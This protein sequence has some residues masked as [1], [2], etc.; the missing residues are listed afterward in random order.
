M[1]FVDEFQEEIWQAKYQY[2]GETYE[3]FCIRIAY[4]IFPDDNKKAEQLKS[5]LMNFRTLFGGRINSNIGIDEKGLTLFNCFIEATVKSPDSLEG[6]FDMLTKY[7]LTLKT[8]GGVGFCANFFRPAKTLI[9]KI[10]VSS[11]GSIKFL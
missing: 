7:A 10:G 6:I 11:P 8:E 1:T 4:T 9:K 2:K 3:G 5:S